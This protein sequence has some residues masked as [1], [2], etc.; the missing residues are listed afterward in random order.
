M[1]TESNTVVNSE[2]SVAFREDQD[3]N[4]PQIL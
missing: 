4:R 2:L 1:R 3:E